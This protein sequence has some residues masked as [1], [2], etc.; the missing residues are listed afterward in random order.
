MYL[1]LCGVVS[2]ISFGL[3]LLFS[4][5]FYPGY[6]QLTQLVSELGADGAPSASAIVMNLLGFGV[7]GALILLF[8]SGCYLGIRGQIWLRSAFALLLGIY[9]AAVMLQGI[10]SCDA[11]CLSVRTGNSSIHGLLGTVQ[12]VSLM[13][14]LLVSVPLLRRRSDWKPFVWKYSLATLAAIFLIFV[15]INPYSGTLIGLNQRVGY[16]AI[17]LW[18]E[19]VALRLYRL[20]RL[21]RVEI[22][23]SVPV[24]VRAP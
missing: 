12:G 4:G 14:A 23:T 8:A 16:L 10:F 11:G 19:I 17:F 3:A 2:P 13:L 1:A 22:T 7:T 21:D 9:G 15:V 6:N 18:L 20:E 5:L 24:L